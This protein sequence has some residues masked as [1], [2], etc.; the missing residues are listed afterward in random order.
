MPSFLIYQVVYS[1]AAGMFFFIL[2]LNLSLR[3]FAEYQLY[4]YILFLRSY[5][6]GTLGCETELLQASGWHHSPAKG[7]PIAGDSVLL[8]ALMIVSVVLC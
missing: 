5:K 1:V 8:P 3:K 2:Y 4:L 7:G 6:I